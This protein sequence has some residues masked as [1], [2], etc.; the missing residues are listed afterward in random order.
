MVTSRLLQPRRLTFLALL[1]PPRSATKGDLPATT[2]Q[3][4]SP[5][6]GNAYNDLACVL[7]RQRQRRFQDWLVVWPNNGAGITGNPAW[8]CQQFT[9]PN[10][11]FAGMQ[12]LLYYTCRS[13]A[14]SVAINGYP[15]LTPG[16][17]KKPPEHQEAAS[18][19]KMQSR[20]V[21]SGHFIWGRDLVTYQ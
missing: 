4:Y 15:P 5:T 12:V 3:P 11:A 14:S 10:I 21:A 13:L 2:S 6:N 19:L 20:Q 18:K 17:F 1:G 7:A 8:H 9:I 16:H